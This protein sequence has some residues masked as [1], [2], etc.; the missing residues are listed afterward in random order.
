MIAPMETEAHYSL[1][2]LARVTGVTPRTVRY[3]IA[4][5]LLPGANE[6]GPGASYDADHLARL[7]LIRELQRQHLPLAEIRTRLA[8][9]RPAEVAALLDEQASP[10]PRSQRRAPPSITSAA[11]S[12]AGSQNAQIT[13]TAASPG[14]RAIHAP[15]PLAR[16]RHPRLLVRCAWHRPPA[17]APRRTSPKPL[18]P[19]M[20]PPRQSDPSGTGSH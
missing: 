8:G 15:S 5:G 16:H 13:P 10:R 17:P 9:L 4:Q 19:L 20:R 3:Y 7:R 2:E 14:A 6:V 18:R 1:A 12:E 11:C